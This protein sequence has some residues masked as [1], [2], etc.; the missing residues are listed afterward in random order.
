MEYVHVC[1]ISSTLSG[2]VLPNVVQR[3]GTHNQIITTYFELQS[4]GEFLINIVSIY[5]HLDC[6]RTISISN[7]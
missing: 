6:I 7:F 5:N 2:F 4:T 1:N 3:E